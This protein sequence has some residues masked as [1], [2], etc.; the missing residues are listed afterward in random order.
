MYSIIWDSDLILRCRSRAKGYTF[1][2]LNSAENEI[3]ITHKQ[4]D[5]FLLLLF[6]Y[7]FKIN[8]VVQ[9]KTRFWRVHTIYVLDKEKYKIMLVPLQPIVSPILKWGVRRFTSH[10]HVYMIIFRF[11]HIHI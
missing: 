11:G 9:V 1:F 5:V 3:H 8:I 4:L 10:G 7:V 2:M 6:F